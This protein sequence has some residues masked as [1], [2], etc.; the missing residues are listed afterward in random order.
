MVPTLLS[1]ILTAAA[2]VNIG[3]SSLLKQL[4]G[5]NRTSEIGKL[6]VG[7]SP[8]VPDG[9]LGRIGGTKE[10]KMTDAQ[11]SVVVAGTRAYTGGDPSV[12]VDFDLVCSTGARISVTMRADASQGVDRAILEA[13]KKLESELTDLADAVQLQVSMRSEELA[14]DRQQP[15]T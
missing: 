14:L 2:F 15:P 7:E 1:I 5:R 9:P 4:S 3:A 6:D 12:H 8:E 10:A 11:V 13:C